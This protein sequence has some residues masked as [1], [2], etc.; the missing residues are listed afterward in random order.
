MDNKSA[1][2]LSLKDKVVFVLGGSSGIELYTRKE[3]LI[4][5]ELL[6]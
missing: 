4:I 6:S 5:T 3:I 2:Y 1:I